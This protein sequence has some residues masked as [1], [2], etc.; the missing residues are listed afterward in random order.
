VRVC[1]VTPY[2][3]SHEGGVNRHARSLAAALRAGGHHVTLVGPASGAVPEGCEG[4]RGVVSVPANGSVARIGLLVPP[5]RTR[6]VIEGGRFDVVHVHEP[7]VPGPGRHALRQAR[8]PVVATFHASAEREPGVQQ[9]LRA[10]AAA[11]LSRVDF[12]IAV[13]RA[14]KRFARIIYRGRTT[15]VPNGVDLSRFTFRGPAAPAERD[16]RAVKVLFVGRYGEPRKGFTVLLDAVALLRAQGR[17]VEVD[18]VGAG[19]PG[20]FQRRADRL[21]VRFLGRVPDAVLAGLYRGADVF[22][23]PSLDGESFGMVLV[24]AMA[25]GCPVVASDLAGY[26]EAARGAALLVPRGDPGVLAVA[27]WRAG[28]DG[29]LRSRLVARGRA[30]ADALC[31]SRIAGRVLHVYAAAARA[32]LVRAPAPAREEPVAP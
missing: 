3:L 23:A 30:R 21:G 1:L 32:A 29:A 31:W 14:A 16:G 15:V 4:L 10:V 8:C 9:A 7:I 19:T 11:G 2:D 13:S 27:L 5:T 17:P 25:A 22:C 12:G 18:V 20:R 24:E 26:A 28:T 6:E